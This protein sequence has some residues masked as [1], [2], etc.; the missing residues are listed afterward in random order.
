MS[1]LQSP[2]RAGSQQSSLQNLLEHSDIRI[3]LQMKHAFVRIAGKGGINRE[4]INRKLIFYNTTLAYADLAD[5]SCVF[6]GEILNCA[7]LFPVRDAHISN[8][9]AYIITVSSQPRDQKREFTLSSF[10][11]LSEQFEAFIRFRAQLQLEGHF[12]RAERIA[13]ETA[14]RFALFDG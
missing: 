5:T 4:L 7:L 8:Q 14:Q 10:F 2:S 12:H 9:R 13:D 3:F 6:Q 1:F 11:A